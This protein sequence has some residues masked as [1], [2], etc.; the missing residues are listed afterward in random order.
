M[1]KIFNI[2]CRDLHISF[3]YY[4]KFHA[5][6]TARGLIKKGRNPRRPQM[7]VNHIYW[8]YLYSV[9]YIKQKLLKLNIRF[10]NKYC[11][12]SSLILVIKFLIFQNTPSKLPYLRNLLFLIQHF[13]YSN[14]FSSYFNIHNADRIVNFGLH[15]LIHD[16]VSS[17]QVK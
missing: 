14:I 1:Q 6:I 7:K 16:T 11:S 5:M 13:I 8:T 17:I 10:I 12:E 2:N 9:I 4:G 3:F 15:L